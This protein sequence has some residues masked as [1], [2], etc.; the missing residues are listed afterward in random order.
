[1]FHDKDEVACYI[2]EMRDYL[3]TTEGCDD[4]YMLGYSVVNCQHDELFDTVNC[5]HE[6]L[7]A[8]VDSEYDG[9]LDS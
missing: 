9:V 6:G 7:F 1:L 4:P 5:E 2:C 8:S 3:Y